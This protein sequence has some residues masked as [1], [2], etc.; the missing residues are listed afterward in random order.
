[1]KWHLDNMEKEEKA[2]RKREREIT[3]EF[4][5]RRRSSLCYSMVVESCLS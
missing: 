3:R 4:V 2:R 5:S 1:V